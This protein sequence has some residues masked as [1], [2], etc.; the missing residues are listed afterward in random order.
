MLG[1]SIMG[2]LEV[3]LI[4]RF[5]LCTRTLLGVVEQMWNPKRGTLI[6][7]QSE[8]VRVPGFHVSL[9]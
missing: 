1:K 5:D 9:K 8:A 3:L 2:F 6:A 7:F 4:R